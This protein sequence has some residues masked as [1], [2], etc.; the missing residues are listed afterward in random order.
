MNIQIKTEQTEDKSSAN[1]VAACGLSG[2]ECL[3]DE[4]RRDFVVGE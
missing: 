3:G 2:V 4:A 1:L